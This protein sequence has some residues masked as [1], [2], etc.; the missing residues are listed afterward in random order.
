[1]DISL[2]LS[3]VVAGL[4]LGTFNALVAASFCVIYQTTKTFHIAHAAV[5][6]LAGYVCFALSRAGLPFALAVA[7][8]CLVAAVAGFLIEWGIYGY[9]RRVH[10][11]TT[12]ILLA[13]LAIL[14][15]TQGVVSIAWGTEVVS[16]RR[17]HNVLDTLAVSNADI[18]MVV[19]CVVSTGLV[20]AAVKWLRIG[21][22]LRAV[23]DGPE[24]AAALGLPVAQTFRFALALGSLALAPAAVAYLWTYGLTPGV[25]LS[26]VLVG[27]IAVML[28]R[29][30]SLPRVVATAV[31]LSVIQPPLTLVVSAPWATGSAY[32]LLLLVIVLRDGLPGRRL[33]AW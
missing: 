16:V 31:A 7:G 10:A 23:G 12:N 26:A 25:G 30:G 15:V 14:I 20:L 13:S 1:M 11:T 17:T 22:T 32:I 18:Y 28:V 21:R 5:F 9:L 8:C 29:S 19:S 33:L 24:V 27:V 4:V 6:V 2:V 3:L